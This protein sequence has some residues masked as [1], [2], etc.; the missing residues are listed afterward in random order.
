MSRAYGFG[1]EVQDGGVAELGPGGTINQRIIQNGTAFFGCGRQPMSIARDVHDANVFVRRRSHTAYESRKEELSE[2]E[3]TKH[4]GSKLHVV[5]VSRDLV[6][7][8]PHHSR[9]IEEDVESTFGS[10]C[11]RRTL[12]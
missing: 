12:R 8:T 11:I 9:R 3:V 5:T 6:Y 7:G 2:I 1:L 10:V 4:I